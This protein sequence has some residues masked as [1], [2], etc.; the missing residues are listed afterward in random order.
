EW[1]TRAVHEAIRVKPGM[2]LCPLDGKLLHYTAADYATFLRKNLNYARLAAGEKK[3]FSP[4]KQWL[5]PAFTFLKEYIFQL[6]FLDGKAGLL[7]AAGNA[8]YKFRKNKRS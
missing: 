1:S 5:S 3:G 6:G 8:R 7:I 4:F 2:Q